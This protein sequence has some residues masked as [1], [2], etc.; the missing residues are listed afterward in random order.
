MDYGIKQ[1]RF[2]HLL[3]YFSSS[4][5]QWIA[6]GSVEIRTFHWKNHHSRFRVLTWRFGV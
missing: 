5:S 6:P 3:P 4:P 1:F 2:I